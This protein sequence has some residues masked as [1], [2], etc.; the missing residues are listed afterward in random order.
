VSRRTCIVLVAAAVA[1]SAPTAAAAPP[2]EPPRTVPG[3]AGAGLATTIDFGAGGTALLTSATGPADDPETVV[4]FATMLQDRSVGG[5]GRLVGEFPA[6]PAVYGRDRVVMLRRRRL[7][8]PSPRSGSA[9]YRLD[10]RFGTIGS[11]LGGRSRRVATFSAIPSDGTP[12]IAADDRGEVAVAWVE[13][14]APGSSAGSYRVRLALGREDRGFGRPQTLASAPVPRVDDSPA[15]RLA[16]GAGGDL[17]VAYTTTRRAGRS[18][19]RFVAARVRRRGGA[20][21]RP[22]VLGPR[23]ASTELTAAIARAGRAVVAWG[24]QDG[25]EGVEL[26][27][28]VRAAVRSAGRT[29]LF[30]RAQLLDPGE[31]RDRPAGRIALAM[32]TE[33]RAT[34]AWSNARGRT[35]PLTYPVRTA[36]TGRTGGFRPVAQLADNGGVRDVAVAADGSTLVAWS[37][38]DPEEERPTPLYARV[39]PAGA[40]A[41]GAAELV[42]PPDGSTIGSDVAY[43]PRTGRPTAVWS[44]LSTGDLQL[45]TRTG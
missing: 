19:R 17:L 4:W 32:S 45:S 27:F 25:G 31:A 42:S 5:R 14:R 21:G 29:A 26:P 37:P 8:R 38:Y 33:G 39:R 3:T 41:F 30:G 40:A 16:Y 35:F 10:A 12:D 13:L 34:L 7:G 23:Q 24:S 1:A 43:S 6:R 36:S 15:V 2:W 9:R 28:E 20:F 18:D 22:Q 11:P 44:V